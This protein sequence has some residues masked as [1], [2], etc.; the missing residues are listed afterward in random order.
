MCDYQRD[1][2]DLE[3]KM[4][5]CKQILRE[6][7]IP[8]RDRKPWI[9]KALQKK[10]VT[11]VAGEFPAAGMGEA[12][13]Q[14]RRSASGT[15][16]SLAR[17]ASVLA[18]ERV[19]A[20]ATPTET[21]SSPRVSFGGAGVTTVGGAESST[22]ASAK[23]PESTGTLSVRVFRLKKLKWEG[24]QGCEYVVRVGY[25][26]FM[27][28]TAVETPAKAS[29]TGADCVVQQQLQIPS[30][31]G[32]RLRCEVVCEG[33]KVVG[34][35]VC[36]ND[37][38]DFTDHVLLDEASASSIGTLIF[39]I[40]R[41]ADAGTK[42]SRSSMRSSLAQQDVPSG[43][44]LRVDKV[45][46][47]PKGA[48]KQSGGVLTVRAGYGPDPRSFKLKTQG[49]KPKQGTHHHQKLVF[50]QSIQL[51]EQGDTT[52]TGVDKNKLTVALFQGEDLISSVA[53][54]DFATKLKHFTAVQL[55]DS[56]GKKC[57]H[58]NLRVDS[59]AK[60]GGSGAGAKSGDEEEDSDADAA[61]STPAENSSELETNRASVKKKDNV[62][63][64]RESK[65]KDE[66]E[67]NEEEEEEEEEEGDE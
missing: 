43:P 47:L 19:S 41:T 61:A 51:G 52:S 65:Q 34:S 35:V 4:N 57:G 31:D 9:D 49:Q 46:D 14:V 30:F 3:R 22:R 53:V 55:K 38:C 5:K 48:V 29:E 40:K 17:G 64:K 1:I 50:Q 28:Q 67:E 39:A 60:P 15:D 36:E 59:S 25:E 13:E 18:S 2:Q 16:P 62:E 32:Q 56:A 27:E 24:M 44:V 11:S 66:E 26:D 63:K 8:V 37:E 33:G 6:P 21:V 23:L 58:V 54:G 42:A 45:A 20:I 12:G 7:Q 10:R